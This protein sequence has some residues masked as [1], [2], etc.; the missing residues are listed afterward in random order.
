[1]NIE[2][3]TPEQQEKVKGCSTPEEI[4]AVAQEEGYELSDEQLE[5]V[6]GGW[7]DDSCPLLCIE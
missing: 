7:K 3:L 1:M 4:L 6:S 5:A 2:G